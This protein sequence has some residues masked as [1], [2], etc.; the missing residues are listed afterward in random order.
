MPYNNAKHSQS[1]FSDLRLEKLIH[2]KIFQ[3][4]TLNQGES[5]SSIFKLMTAEA[6]GAYST[7][8]KI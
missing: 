7:L 1:I 8:I 6:Y 3:F 4:L 2:A 5:Y